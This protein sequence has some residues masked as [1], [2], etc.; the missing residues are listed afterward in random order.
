MIDAALVLAFMVWALGVGLANRRRASR[1]LE[2][3]FLAGRSLSGWESGLSMAATQYAADTP[4]L[5]AGLVATGGVFALWRLWSYGIAFL[6]LGLLLGAAW[7]RVGVLTD[8]ELCEIRYSGRPAAWL[9]GVKAAYYGLV[10]NCAV[11]AM[12]LAAAVRVAARSWRI[13]GS[14]RLFR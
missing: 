8:A 1:D 4:L 2:S 3:Y 7:W 10:F 11:L 12:V 14:H 6:L 13:R 5:A 9:R